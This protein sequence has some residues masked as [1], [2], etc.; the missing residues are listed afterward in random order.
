MP[1]PAEILENLSY[2]SQTYRGYAL[3][4][5]LIIFIFLLSLIKFRPTNR[6]FSSLLSLPLFSVS[7][8]AWLS[9]NPFNGTVFLIFAIV[10]V[11]FG[12]RNSKESASAGPPWSVIPG[13]IIV[14]FGLIYPHFLED[15]PFISY[16]YSAPTCLIPCPT[17][18]LVIGLSI[19]FNG[20][21]S[22]KWS[23]TLLI[24]GVFYGL[25]GVFRLGVNLDIF[26]LF[27]DS[28]FLI[29]IIKMPE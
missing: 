9:G 21:R 11:L 5:H 8:F 18:S 16:L 10:L 12:I 1:S 17:L 25:F 29:T 23:V 19:I 2:I 4:C 3:A 22:R 28:V 26:L 13:I 15:Q 14:I 6:L 20:F 24:I 27:A 7:I